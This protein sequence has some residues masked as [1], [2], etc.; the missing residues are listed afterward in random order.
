MDTL[1]PMVNEKPVVIFSK[2]NTDPVSH[3]MKQLISSYGANPTVY[4][5]DEIP[6]G[7]EVGNALENIGHTRN[8]PAIFIGGTFI[9]GPNEV[10]GLQVRGELVQK[11]INAGAIW[12]WNR[13]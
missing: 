8:L 11:L 4:E 6:N 12:V 3:S 7:G 5:M 13:S 10:I 9:G 1:K 2:T